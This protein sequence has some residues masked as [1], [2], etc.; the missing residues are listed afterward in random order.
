MKIPGKSIFESEARASVT[1]KLQFLILAI[2]Q[3]Q[4]SFLQKRCFS[5]FFMVADLLSPNRCNWQIAQFKNY[6]LNVTENLDSTLKKG[7]PEF[8]ILPPGSFF[9]HLRAGETKS[10]FFDQGYPDRN[11]LFPDQLRDIDF[12]DSLIMMCPSCSHHICSYPFAVRY[13]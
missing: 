10:D 11:Q 8:S 9:E 4:R 2:Y 6:N 1:F 12:N 7:F 3:L 5:H 13:K